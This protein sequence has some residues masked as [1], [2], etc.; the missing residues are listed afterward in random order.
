MFKAICFDD[1]LDP[2]LDI[3]SDAIKNSYK[4]HDVNEQHGNAYV[5]ID[6]YRAFN[7]SGK[8]GIYA[9]HEEN[10]EEIMKLPE[11][12]WVEYAS[13]IGAKNWHKMYDMAEFLFNY[14][15][16]AKTLKELI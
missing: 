12:T 16:I 7:A 8:K 13:M 14:D 15:S 5:F 10:C 9:W 2:S 11:G 6:L 4:A 3:Y 1:K